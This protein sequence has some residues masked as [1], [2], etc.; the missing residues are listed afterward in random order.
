MAITKTKNG[1]K[2]QPVDPT[3]SGICPICG[4]SYTFLGSDAFTVSQDRG[5]GAI[6]R[7]SIKCTEVF[8]G[9]PC[10]GVV[11]GLPVMMR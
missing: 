2:W 7:A 3:F 5:P 9:V 6:P 10:G 1:T 8:D 11:K 4:A